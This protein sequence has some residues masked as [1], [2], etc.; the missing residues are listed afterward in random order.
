MTWWTGD[1]PRPPHSFDHVIAA[2]PASAFFRWN[3]LAC[4]NPSSPNRLCHVSNVPRLGSAFAAR[5][6]RASARNAA[7]SFVSLKSMVVLELRVGRGR[8][9]GAVRARL[10][11]ADEEILPVRHAPEHQPEELGAPV[12]EMAIEL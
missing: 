6:A 7:S 11:P 5:N 4:V 3:A 8:R 10:D 2:K 9:R 1:S 12:V